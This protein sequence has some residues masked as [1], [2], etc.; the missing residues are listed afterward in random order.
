MHRATRRSRRRRRRSRRR[1][2]PSRSCRSRQRRSAPRRPRR[3]AGRARPSAAARTAAAARRSSRTRSRYSSTGADA[4]R[5]GEA[6]GDPS[7]REPRAGRRRP[8]RARA[9]ALAASSSTS[10]TTR[11][12]LPK[13]QSPVDAQR[14]ASFSDGRAVGEA[15]V[16]LADQL[17]EVAVEVDERQLVGRPGRAR[18]RGRGRRRRSAAPAGR[19]SSSPARTGRGRP[20]SCASPRTPRSPRPSRSRSGSP[21]ACSG[22]PGSTFLTLRISGRPRMPSRRVERVL[23]RARGR[24]TGCWWSRTGAGRGR[25]APPGPR[26][27]SARSRAARSGRRSCGGRSGRPCGPT[28]VRR[29]A[30]IANGAPRRG[31]PAG[32]PGVG[33]RAEVVGVGDERVAVAGVDQ[34]V[35]QAGAEQRGVEVAVPGRTPLQRR[36]ARPA[37]RREVVD[38]QLGLLVLQELQRQPVDGEVVVAGQRGQGVG[39]RCGSC[40]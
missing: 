38:Q 21:R 2:R 7:R 22:R 18:S 4:G 31:E 16:E 32:D 34:P 39:A 24:T 19:W 11:T 10:P 29:T 35:E 25:P 14:V 6:C 30:S 36:V 27:A 37:D 28:G 33:H 5:V 8:H 9:D 1:T 3:P 12:P 13:V 26:G 23:H 15:L 40:S 20:R 17:V